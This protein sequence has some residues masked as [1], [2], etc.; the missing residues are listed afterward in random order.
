MLCFYRYGF[1]WMTLVSFV[2]AMILLTITMIDF[3]TMTIPNG[4]VIALV[5][6]VIVCAVLEPQ[7]SISSRVIGMASVSG[8]MLLMTLAIPDCF[9]GGDMKLM[10]VCGFMLGW[11]NTLLA[12]FIG[13][14]AGGIYA[15][16]LMVTKKSKEQSHMAFGPY[17]CLGI[18]IALLYGNEIIRV[19]L[20]F[21]IYKWGREMAIYKYVARDIN[22]KKITGKTEAR[23]EHELSQLLRVKDMYLIST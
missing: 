20:S 8:F 3:D 6:P 14:L 11:I 10:F 7:I 9:G 23:D 17:L 19:Y 18:F 12:G 15:S 5:A 2:L 1:T 13:L 22:A 4:L 16:Y 21:L